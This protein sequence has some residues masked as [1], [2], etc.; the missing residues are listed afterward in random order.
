[1]PIT[2]SIT[3]KLN[4]FIEVCKEGDLQKVQQLYNTLN[5]T[6]PE[7]ALVCAYEHN[8]FKVIMFILQVNPDIHIPYYIDLLYLVCQHGDLDALKYFVQIKKIDIDNCDAEYVFGIACEN[9]HLDVVK[10]LHEIDFDIIS[11]D[12]EYAF[13]MACKNGHLHVV[14]HLLEIKPDINISIQEEYAFRSA[15]QNG[16]LHVVKHLLEIKPDINISIQ[17]ECAF[18]SACQNGHLDMAKYLLEIKPD[19]NIY[20]VNDIAFTGACKNGHL[21]VV[22]FLIE[23]KPDWDIIGWNNEI[24]TTYIAFREACDNGHLHV[25]RFLLERK[26]ETNKEDDTIYHGFRDACYHGHLEVVKYLSQ[27]KPEIDIDRHLIDALSRACCNGHIEVVKFLIEIKPALKFGGNIDKLFNDACKFK[28]ALKLGGNND[29]LF[30]DARK[31]QHLELVKYLYEI[32]PNVVILID[33]FINVCYSGK[34]EVVEFIL[35]NKPDFDICLNNDRAFRSACLNGHL[36]IAQLLVQKMP[37]KYSITNVITICP[38]E[39]MI[40]YNINRFGSKTKYVNHIEKCFVCTTSNCSV[41]TSCNHTFCKKCITQWLSIKEECP[42]C[43]SAIL[44]NHVF[45]TLKI[46]K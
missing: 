12:Y 41:K 27:F 31:I 42:Y 38:G 32:N 19:I 15:C 17:E 21:E 36:E 23:L 39:Y 22:K 25:I 29:K 33:T 7:E 14:K 16:H 35:K 5:T 20:A 9:G 46:K 3:N 8:H 44:P 1:M 26:P 2:R 34:L 37:D 43:R 45:T 10:Y 28:P 6:I 40:S 4:Q 30:N 18:R 11:E 13:K 24:K